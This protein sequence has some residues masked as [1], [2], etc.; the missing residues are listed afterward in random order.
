MSPSNSASPNGNKITLIPKRSSSPSEETSL[1]NQ[2]EIQDKFGEFLNTLSEM[3]QD[4]TALEVNTMVV[5]KIT[6]AKFNPLEAYTIIY[7]LGNDPKVLKAYPEELHPRY[8][9][10]WEQLKAAYRLCP[11][12]VTQMKQG[13]AL[14]D[15]LSDDPDEM[16]HLMQLMKI[17]N[18]VRTLR[19]LSELRAALDGGNP[20]S[21]TIDIIYAQTVMQLDGDVI[22]RYNQ[23]LFKS[24]N[25]KQR[26]F[27][28]NLHNQGV[29]AGERQWRG[30]INF[31]VDLLKGFVKG[32]K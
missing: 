23:E 3:L 9:R 12:D 25:E 16:R 19:K 26:D 7:Q 10:L 22:N 20:K 28:V 31:M 21:T 27:I 24:E 13:M 17:S 29:E 8:V 30:L 6:G 4:F 1:S 14:P 18:L 2:A 5:S 15:P 32:N 11:E